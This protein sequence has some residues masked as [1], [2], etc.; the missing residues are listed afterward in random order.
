MKYPYVA[1]RLTN[2][3]RVA[4]RLR[5]ALRRRGVEARVERRWSVVVHVDD[6]EYARQLVA[7]EA[8]YDGP[9]PKVVK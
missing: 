9:P 4:K 6:Y 3:H 2:D 7:A 1:F 5:R 8:D